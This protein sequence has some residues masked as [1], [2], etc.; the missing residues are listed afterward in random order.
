MFQEPWK[1]LRFVEHLGLDPKLDAWKALL[2]DPSSGSRS[3]AA[4]STADLRA[5]KSESRTAPGNRDILGGPQ[6]NNAKSTFGSSHYPLP[7]Q[8]PQRI[9]GILSIY[10]LYSEAHYTK[11]S[12]QKRRPCR[13]QHAKARGK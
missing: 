2:R 3:Q 6:D 12:G 10:Y 7:A 8:G 1:P 5:L 13:S 4:G 9:Y 11:I